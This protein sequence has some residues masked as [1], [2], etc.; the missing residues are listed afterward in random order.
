MSESQDSFSEFSS[1]KPVITDDKLDQMIY[2]N[3]SAGAGSGASDSFVNSEMEE[4][5]K[6]LQE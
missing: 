3:T 5:R 2:G 4:L 6:M 1:E